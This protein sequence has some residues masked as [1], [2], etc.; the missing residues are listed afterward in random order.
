MAWTT[1]K[2]NWATG[3]LV[4]AQDMNAVGENL[5]TLK[6]PPTV[7]HIT[8]AE[9][10]TAGST[11]NFV[12][13]DSDNLS[14][15]ISTSGGDELAHFDCMVSATRNVALY[16]Y[17]DIEIDGN[18]LG[19][20]FGIALARANQNRHGHSFTRLIQGLNAGSHTLKLQWKHTHEFRTHPGAQFWVREI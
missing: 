13:A 9:L 8:T 6:V 11:T 18:R 2:T 17:L 5:A 15:T 7:A 1:P 19:D 3:E 12:D 16:L 4:T 14:L 10:L 20:E